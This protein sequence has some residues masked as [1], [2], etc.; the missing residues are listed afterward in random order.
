MV[1]RKSDI[2]EKVVIFGA[3]GMLGKEL[4][5][6]F[7]KFYKVISLTHADLDIADEDAVSEKIFRLKPSIIINA[8]GYTNVDL[9]ETERDKAFALNA[10]AISYLSKAANK[11]G[12]MLATYSSD[13]V[14]SGEKDGEYDENCEGDSPLNVYG[15]SKLEGEKSLKN[16]CKKFYLIRTSWLY[17]NGK[18]FVDT[19]LNSAKTEIKVVSDQI[20][21]PTYAKDLAIA[22][23]SLIKDH[24]SYGTYHLVNEGE[25]SWYDFAKK[26]F[27]IAGLNVKVTAVTSDEFK[28]LAKRPLNSRLLNSKRPRLRSVDKALKS[29]LETK[30]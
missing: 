10:H 21:K 12:A 7:S 3:N 28:R 9:A 13:Y 29:Y 8:A 22:T 15:K 16:T 25:L 24:P 14:F 30:I 6:V 1:Q 2:L 11:C 27:Q 26:I 19:M 4:V 20:G 18:N 23:L 5:S 17:G